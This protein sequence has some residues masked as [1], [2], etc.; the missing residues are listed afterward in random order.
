LLFAVLLLVDF[1][2]VEVFPLFPLFFMEFL[3]A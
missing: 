2:F 3:R 1:F